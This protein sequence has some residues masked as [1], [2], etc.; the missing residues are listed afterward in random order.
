MHQSFFSLRA[1]PGHPG[2]DLRASAG[3]GIQPV[4]HLAR[5]GCALCLALSFASALQAQQSVGKASKQPPNEDFY[6]YKQIPD[7]TVQDSSGSAIRLSKIWQDK[8]VL[9]TMVFTRCAGVCSPFL[10]SF[11]SAASAAGGQGTDY[12]V[13]VLSFD[14][15]DS[16]ADMNGMADDL[17]LKLNSAW[18]FGIASPS[19]I[20]RLAEA[21]GIWFRWDESVQQYDHPAVVVAIEQGRVVRMLAGATVPVAKLS[22]VIQELRGKFVPSYSLPGKVAFR[23][24]EYDPNSGHYTLDWGLLLMILPG[25]AAILATA[26]IFFLVPTRS[27]MTDS[28]AL[29]R[30]S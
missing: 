7:I 19:D 9:L 24:F 22:E 2:S 25:T 3:S 21:T 4:I 26:W 15:K 20:R 29:F 14:P 13:L 27:R 6:V 23:C 12:R 5:L 10:H 11:K 18:I 28:Y 30:T 1:T 17:G 16:I 8:P